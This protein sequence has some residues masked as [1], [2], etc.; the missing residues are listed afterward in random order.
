MAEMAEMIPPITSLLKQG[1]KYLFTPVL[2]VIVQ[3]V[4]EELS[5]PPVLVYPD[6]DEVAENF[7]P[8]PLYCDASSID[9]YGATL[10]Q[11]Q[12]DGP[13]RPIVFISRATLESERH[14]TPLD[15]EAGSIVWNIERLRGCLWRTSFC[16]FSGHTT[17]ESLAK[18][19]ER[20]PREFLTAYRYTLEYPKGTANGNAD[21]LS[22]PFSCHAACHVYF[23]SSINSPFR[24]KPVSYRM[25]FFIL[26]AF[27]L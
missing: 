23:D 12:N 7:R 25:L 2:G 18:V 14:R 11:E 8:A 5:A 27:A 20:N 26:P 19:A 16:F 3:K 13:I 15:L 10:G 9:G 24:Y 17:L 22:R 6:W 21:F 4:L 1:V